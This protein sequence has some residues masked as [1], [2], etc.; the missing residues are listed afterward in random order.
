MLNTTAPGTGGAGTNLPGDLGSSTS[1]P[2]QS[3]WNRNVHVEKSLWCQLRP[4]PVAEGDSRCVPRYGP[5]LPSRILPMV[6]KGLGSS[7]SI[8]VAGGSPRKA[9][10]T[11][12]Q[13]KLVVCFRVVLVKEVG[14]DVRH[15]DRKR[16]QDHELQLAAN[17]HKVLATSAKARDV[18]VLNPD[19]LAA[20]RRV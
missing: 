9:Q 6:R 7:A 8:E 4:L 17:G 11:V 1:R 15:P 20:R 16:T 5:S 3:S 10:L 14:W 18:L 12:E 19:V 2:P 13:A